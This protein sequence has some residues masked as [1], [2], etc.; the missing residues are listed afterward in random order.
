MKIKVQKRHMAL[1]SLILVLGMTNAAMFLEANHAINLINQ[2]AQAADDAGSTDAD[3]PSDVEATGVNTYAELVQAIS[4][5]RPSI[6]LL[7]S[8]KATE[9]LVINHDVVLDLGIYNIESDVP[10][11]RVIDIHEGTVDIISSATDGGGQIIASGEGGVAVR[12]YGAASPVAEHSVVTIGRNVTLRANPSSPSSYAMFVSITDD[13][14]NAY[15]VQI[16]FQGKIVAYNGLYVNGFVQHAEGMPK[17]LVDDGASISANS[18]GGAAIY[19]AGYADWNIGAATLS[20]GTGVV[21]KSGL[22]TTTSSSITATGTA[23]ANQPDSDGFNPSGAVFQI[24]DNPSYAGDMHLVVDG[25]VYTST[26]NGVFVEYGPG[27]SSGNATITVKG[28]KFVAGGDQNAFLGVNPDQ[29]KVSGGTFN[30]EV[31]PEL[32]AESMQIKQNAAGQWVVSPSTT[33]P[34]NPDQPKPDDPN[35][36]GD[37]K[38][39]DD[40]K[41]DTQKPSEP[42][43]K[44]GSNSPNTGSTGATKMNTTAAMATTIGSG[45]VI[46]AAAVIWVY[47]FVRNVAMKPSTS[48]STA[49]K[50]ATRSMNRDINN[51]EKA[52]KSDLRRA[53]NVARTAKSQTT[54]LKA[55]AKRSAS[56][57]D[58]EV[59]RAGKTVS[60]D[61]KR[62]TQSV[63]SAAKK[64]K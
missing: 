34:P 14:H 39:D 46:V 23:Q 24:E 15:G 26:N 1:L 20:G 25:G 51:L 3:A 35:D 30:T 29:V 58:R 11:A 8:I 33:T 9:N 10:N 44:P 48:V 55:D 56:R 49:S 13:N 21:V 17:I 40:K 38:P 45:L 12:V 53:K 19:G 36:P 60:R 41:D 6:K 50:S 59:K 7:S 22:V 18:E 4:D 42:G 61:L 28:G 5:Q 16:N 31:A 47:R 54:R 64:R 52:A 37:D 27:R 63:K 43:K 32:L 57:V 62:G 2:V